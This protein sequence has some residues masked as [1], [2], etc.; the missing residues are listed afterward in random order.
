MTPCARSLAAETG[1]ILPQGHALDFMIAA[2]FSFTELPQIHRLA[3]VFIPTQRGVGFMRLM[4]DPCAAGW[5]G[6]FSGLTLAMGGEK[7]ADGVV[8][9]ISR[10]AVLAVGTRDIAARA[11]LVD[12]VGLPSGK[13]PAQGSCNLLKKTANL[14][15]RSDFRRD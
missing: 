13:I 5:P 15:K 2:R 6:V 10:H 9:V 8:T 7:L 4:G 3:E 11:E 14:V 12:D 1:N